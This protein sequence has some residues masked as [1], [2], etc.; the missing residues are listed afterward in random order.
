LVVRYEKWEE[1]RNFNSVELKDPMLCYAFAVRAHKSTHIQTKVDDASTDSLDKHHDQQ[2]AANCATKLNSS[3]TV[4]R[5]I[6]RICKRMTHLGFAT[7]GLIRSNCLA[8]RD[9]ASY[10]MRGCKD[11][12]KGAKRKNTSAGTFV[13]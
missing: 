1:N 11:A 2:V 6:A 4:V 12:P 5:R 7:L 8:H 13:S 3:L 9:S 10:R